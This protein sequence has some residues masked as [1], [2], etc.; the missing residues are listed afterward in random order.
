MSGSQFSIERGFAT[1]PVLLCGRRQR[2]FGALSWLDV[3]LSRSEMPLSITS[4]LP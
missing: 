3:R 4:C 2:R 1:Q